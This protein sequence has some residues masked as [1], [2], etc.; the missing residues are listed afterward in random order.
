M[1]ISQSLIVL[2]PT[3]VIRNF[4]SRLR[5]RADTGPVPPLATVS[6]GLIKMSMFFMTAL[7]TAL[8][9]ARITPTGDRA[10]VSNA[11]T[12]GNRPITRAAVIYGI[13]IIIS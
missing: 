9:R 1:S 7:C 6:R 11:E 5:V 10:W 4:S 3:A 2:S 12:S 8:D 13:L